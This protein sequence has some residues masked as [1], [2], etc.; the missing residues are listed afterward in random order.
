MIDWPLF[1]IFLATTYAAGAT[2][3]FFSPDGWYDRID[4][5]KWTPPNWLFPVAWF[6]L[7]I[8]MAYAATRV[9]ISG[10]PLLVYALAIWGLQVA[11]NTLW[12]PVFFGLHRL[13]AALVVLCGMWISVLAM[14]ISFYQADMIAGLLILPYVVWTSYAWALNFSIWRRN[15]GAVQPA[16]A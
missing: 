4:K 16:G 8:C 10:S 1:V 2:G 3:A 7:Y 13:G 11:F 12:S 5:P 6:V 15:R 9:A 14:A